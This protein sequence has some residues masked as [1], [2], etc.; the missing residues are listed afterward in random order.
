M[1]R[2]PCAWA[3]DSRIAGGQPLAEQQQPFQALRRG[4]VQAQS[5]NQGPVGGPDAFARAGRFDPQLQLPDRGRSHDRCGGMARRG[6]RAL[7]E[8]AL[9]LADPALGGEARSRRRAGGADERQPG[10]RSLLPGDHRARRHDGQGPGAIE[11][12]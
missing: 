3:A 7:R 6:R 1:D 5:A 10:Q 9:Q 11:A 2:T 12:P 4:R 8:L